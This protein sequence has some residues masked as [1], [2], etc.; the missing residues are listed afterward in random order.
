M[1]RQLRTFWNASVRRDFS[2]VE[3]AVRPVQAE[4]TSPARETARELLAP[5]T[6]RLCPVRGRQRTAYATKDI[7]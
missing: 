4:S 2:R 5:T 1:Q 7:I 6:E 3:T